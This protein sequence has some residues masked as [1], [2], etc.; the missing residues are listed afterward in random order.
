MDCPESTLLPLA[1]T[2][3]K[4][5]SV[6]NVGK[7]GNGKNSFLRVR[8][9][10]HFMDFSFLS[11]FQ[12]I[13]FTCSSLTIIQGIGG[14]SGDQWQCHFLVGVIQGNTLHG[15]SW[16]FMDFHGFSWIFMDFH[17]FSWNFLD[18]HGNSWIF[19]D[20]S[21]ILKLRSSIWLR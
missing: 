3:F 6:I 14:G 13:G 20:L 18:F 1:K 4:G 16:I 15:F 19:R 21:T 12:A 17:G 5:Q 11:R 7:Y 8:A 9:W 2:Q 10:V